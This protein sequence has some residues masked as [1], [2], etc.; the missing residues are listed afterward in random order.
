MADTTSLP[1]LDVAEPQEKARDNIWA[2]TWNTW[3]DSAYNAMVADRVADR[4][5]MFDDTTKVV[6][7]LTSTGSAVA[8]WS[9]WHDPSGRAWWA[10]LAGFGVLISIVHT[11][12]NV[13]GRLKDWIEVKKALAMLE[14]DLQTFQDR[15]G[16]DPR[17]PIPDFTKE[18]SEYRKR[19]GE[20]AQG[21]PGGN[22][23]TRRLKLEVQSELDK[24]ISRGIASSGIHTSRGRD[25]ANKSVE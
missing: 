23:F 7:A 19:Y 3:Y 22:R 8:G 5:K 10:I 24:R 9:L 16:F 18:F 4:W 25:D 2:A 14:I 13:G 1:N 21:I 11:S 6:V 17:F 15:M 12:L 20:A